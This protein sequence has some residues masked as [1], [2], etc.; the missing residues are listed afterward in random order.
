MGTTK[1]LSFLPFLPAMLQGLNGWF[2]LLDED[3]GLTEHQPVPSSISVGSLTAQR[4]GANLFA[5]SEETLTL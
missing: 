2:Q 3:K 1:S 4:P 5:V